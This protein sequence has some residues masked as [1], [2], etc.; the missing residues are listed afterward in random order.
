MVVLGGGHRPV[1]LV[2]AEVFVFR[3][4]PRLWMVAGQPALSIPAGMSA[5][6]LPLSVQLVGRPGAEDLLYALAGQIEAARPWAQL[7]P[8]MAAAVPS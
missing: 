6:G 1:H 7:K 5:D 3:D 2:H 8:P 4:V